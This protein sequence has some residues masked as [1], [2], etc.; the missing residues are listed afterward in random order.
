MLDKVKIF[1][2]INNIKFLYKDE[3]FSKI[4]YDKW[5]IKSYIR[6]SKIFYYTKKFLYWDLSLKDYFVI[7]DI[8]NKK[9]I[10]HKDLFFEKIFSI[11]KFQSNTIYIFYKDS[12][13]YLNK[14]NKI[15]NLKSSYIYLLNENKLEKL[16]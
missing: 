7:W 15:N 16:N 3:I 10:L 14:W 2:E 1:F 12:F 13:N 5:D 6:Y 4:F 9:N 8:Y 11:D